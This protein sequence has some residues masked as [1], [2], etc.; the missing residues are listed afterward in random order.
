MADLP[1]LIR[2]DENLKI[3]FDLIP[4]KESDLIVARKQVGS[5]FVNNNTVKEKFTVLSKED[6]PEAPQFT[7]LSPHLKQAEV[8]LSIRAAVDSICRH[9]GTDINTFLNYEEEDIPDQKEDP[10]DDVV[11]GFGH[12]KSDEHRNSRIPFRQRR[13]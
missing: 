7:N 13:A 6:I 4:I 1:R 2:K 3:D 12:R 8:V 10:F 9:F 5:K 11:L